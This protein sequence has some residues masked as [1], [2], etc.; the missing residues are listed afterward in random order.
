M[1][2]AANGRIGAKETTPLR[3]CSAP[4]MLRAIGETEFRARVAQTGTTNTQP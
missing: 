4:E 3:D 1:S 2:K